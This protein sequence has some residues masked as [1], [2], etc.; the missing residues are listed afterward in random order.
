MNT[1]ETF[2][3]CAINFKTQ[4]AYINDK[5]IHINN[6]LEFY[7]IYNK[8][9]RPSIL[10]RAVLINEIRKLQQIAKDTNVPPLT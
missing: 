6:C 1:N 3:K 4:Y 5:R 7:N 9:P 10:P 8:F 2:E